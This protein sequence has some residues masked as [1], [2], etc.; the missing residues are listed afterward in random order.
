METGGIRM[1]RKIFIVMILLI[2]FLSGCE[3]P[4]VTFLTITMIDPQPTNGIRF[5]DDLLI[6]EFGDVVLKTINAKI[7]NKSEKTIR[8]IWDE[9]VYID[10]NRK[11]SRAIHTD[12]LAIDRQKTIIPTVIPAGTYVEI[13]I[14]PEENIYW[15]SSSSQYSSSGWRIR[16]LFTPSPGNSLREFSGE[17]FAI[18]VPVEV[19]EEII[20]Y[21]F[22]F[23]ITYQTTQV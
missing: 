18:I 14:V 15:C 9:A 6:V 1:K 11:V 19:G 4:T 12:V 7:T 3:Q 10:N 16:N 8:L 22:E 21:R 23:E 2:T 5:E 13:R 17:R 20:E